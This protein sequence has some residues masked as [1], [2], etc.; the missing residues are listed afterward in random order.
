[1]DYPLF[2]VLPDLERLTAPGGG[3]RLYDLRKQIEQSILTSHGD[4]LAFFVTFLDNHD[5]KAPIRFVQPGDED[6]FDDPR[7]RWAWPAFYSLPG[8][9][10][11]YYGTEQGLHGSGSDPA[12]R[13]AV[14]GITPMFPRN[15][16]FYSEIQEV[17]AVA[18]TPSRR[19]ATGGSI[20]DPSRRRRRLFDISRF[21]PESWHG[22]GD[23]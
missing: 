15:G 3:G 20:S 12:V 17:A 9:P 18:Q 6:E 1:M 21:P 22:R 10:C 7:S 5:M 8:I 16:I 14:W 11:L 23:F 2:H 13:E 19:S 4:A